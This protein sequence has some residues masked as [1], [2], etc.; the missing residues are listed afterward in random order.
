MKLRILGPFAPY[1]PVDRACNGYLVESGE[2]RVMLDCGNGAFAKMQKYCDFRRL[3][4]LIITHY[5]PDHFHD[6]HCVRHAVAGSLRDG[7]RRE[8]LLVFAPGEGEPWV[9]MSEWQ[10]VFELRAVEDYLGQFAGIGDISFYFQQNIHSVPSFAV[11]LS[12]GFNK[13]V[14]TSD[15][16]WYE[17]LADFA[18]EAD[19]LLCEASQLNADYE[20]SMAKGHLT[21]GQAGYLAA[22]AGVKHLVLTHLWPEM[23]YRA[24]A[25]EAADVFDGEITLAKE[26]L[27]FL[28]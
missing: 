20:I 26:G 28:A 21:G 5:H 1:A 10:G 8:P 17:R 7:S 27:S 11:S 22:Q 6:Y 25:A 15:T 19:I 3:N 4:A 23:D 12:N 14:Y 9:E 2:T 18:K 24:L 13:I 16:R